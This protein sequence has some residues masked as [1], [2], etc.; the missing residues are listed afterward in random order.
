MRHH[1]RA[2]AEFAAFITFC[3]GMCGAV[4]ILF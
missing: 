3:A 1:F 2:A 4:A